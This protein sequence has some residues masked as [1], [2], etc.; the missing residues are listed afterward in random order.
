MSN[1]RVSELSIYPVK[2]L[3]GIALQQ[4]AVER[5]GLRNDRRWMVVDDHD[6]YLTQREQS[7]MCLIQPEPLSNGLRLSAPGMETL[8]IT[9]TPKMP[10]REVI[11]WN[12]RCRALDCG[13]AAAGWLGRFLGIDCRLVYFPDDGRR[14][15]DPAYARAGDITAFSDGFPVLLITQ[16]SLDDLNDRLAEPLSMRRFRPNLVIDGSEPY[17]EDQW[18][19]LRIGDLTLRVVK[20]CSRCVIPTIDPASGKRHT[21]AEPLRTLATYRM[22]DHKIFFGQNVIVDGGGRFEVGQP[23]EVLDQARLTPS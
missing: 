21:D 6:R 19:R 17:A 13:D 7:R 22:R 18:K 20:P 4:S 10:I 11:V 2:S 8:Q 16:A 3:G 9:H 5:F 23:V 15:V 1:L 14:A 12:D